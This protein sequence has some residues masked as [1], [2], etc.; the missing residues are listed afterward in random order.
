M[1]PETKRKIV[2]I[3]SLTVVIAGIAVIIGWIF[4]IRAL[5]SISPFWISMKFDTAIAFSFSGV[6]L[7]SIA[8]AKEDEFDKAQVILSI[9]SLIVIL[10]MGTLLLSN[11]LGIHTGAEDLFI[12][13]TM[14]VAKTVIPGRPSFPTMVS[15]ILIASGGIFTILQHKKLHIELKI[16]GFTVTV[17]GGL[18]AAGYILNVPLLYYFINGV[19]SAMACHTAILFSL[20]GLGLLCL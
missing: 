14:P 6:I 20:L 13:E 10:L 9:S 11:L 17:I 8:M 2:K 4:D 15:F 12:Q 18:A 16:I 1:K 3:V 19:N 7:Y 5:K